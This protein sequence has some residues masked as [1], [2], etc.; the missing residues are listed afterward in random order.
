MLPTLSGTIPTGDQWYYEPKLDGYRATLYVNKENISFI[1]RNL[2]MLNEQFPELV[3]TTKEHLN[4]LLLYSPIVIDGEI[5]ILETETKA[6]FEQIQQ[7]GKLKTKQKIVKASKETP[8]TFACFDLLVMKGK[9]I[10]T[11]L[12]YVERKQ[13]LANLFTTVSFGSSY[14]YVK[15]TTNYQ[16]LWKLVQA[17]DGEG[18]VAKKKH[19]SWQEGIRTKEWLKIKNLSIATV[20]IIGLDLN[21]QYVQVGVID[22]HQIQ[23]IG[24]VGQGFS[25]DEKEALVSIIMKNKYKADQQFIYVKPSI[26]LEIEFLELYKG[27]IRHPKFRRFRFDKQWEECTWEAIKKV[28][29]V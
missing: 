6:N 23:Q 8:A 1:S 11:I 27:Q 24:I 19:S 21:N 18:I 14:S 12:P 15:E 25:K 7:R 9:I 17:K 2:K 10:G 20:F 16:S 5:C 22:N 3:N 26:C 4:A 29:Q 13:L 28:E